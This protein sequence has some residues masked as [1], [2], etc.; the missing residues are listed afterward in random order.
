MTT[1]TIEVDDD[2]LARAR[3]LATARSISVTEVFQRLLR[4]AIQPPLRREDLPPL[5]RQAQGILPP[6]SDE[7]AKDALDEHRTRKYGA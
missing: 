7:Q 3:E 4:E 1:V 6:M 2:L 5:T